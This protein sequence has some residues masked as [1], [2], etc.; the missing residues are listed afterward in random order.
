MPPAETRRVSSAVPGPADVFA[1]AEA[2]DA[3]TQSSASTHK[4]TSRG[5]SNG[6]RT[7][8]LPQSEP[9]TVAEV[10]KIFPQRT[11]RGKKQKHI[12]HDGPEAGAHLAVAYRTGIGVARLRIDFTDEPLAVPGTFRMDFHRRRNARRGVPPAEPFRHF[13]LLFSGEHEQKLLRFIAIDTDMDFVE[14]RNAG[15][16][17]DARYGDTAH[18]A[19]KKEVFADKSAE[20]RPPCE[21]QHHGK[22]AQEERQR[23]AT[24][25][26]KKTMRKTEHFS[27]PFGI[28]RLRRRFLFHGTSLPRCEKHGE[29][30]KRYR[31]QVEDLLHTGPRGEVIQIFHLERLNQRFA[32]HE[33]RVIIDPGPLGREFRISGE[34]RGGLVRKSIR[35][36]SEEHT[37]ELQSPDH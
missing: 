33:R 26:V 9:G 8:S 5:E 21:E 12:Q 37:S 22:N 23:E 25:T 6:T 27:C 4:I 7:G 18:C 24:E 10:S 34:E 36:R 28:F 13:R 3:D 11:V 15:P 35:E 31:K 30:K 14:Q 1:R 32:A 2:P 19:V 16:A 17:P 29:Q 20:N